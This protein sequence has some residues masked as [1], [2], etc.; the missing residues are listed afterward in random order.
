MKKNAIITLIEN[1][2]QYEVKKVFFEM[3]PFG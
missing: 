2:H 1:V 3:L